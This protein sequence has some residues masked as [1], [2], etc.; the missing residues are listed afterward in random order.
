MKNIHCE[1]DHTG[2][3]GPGMGGMYD[4]VTELPFVDHEPGKCECRNELHL[5]IRDGK[6]VYLCSCCN[7]SGDLLVSDDASSTAA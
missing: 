3:L 6:R 7:M 1:C 2:K 4:P 5:Y